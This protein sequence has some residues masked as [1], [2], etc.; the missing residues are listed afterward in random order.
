[1]KT[2]L[3]WTSEKIKSSG[4]RKKLKLIENCRKWFELD[5]VKKWRKHVSECINHVVYYNTV[6]LSIIK[7]SI[8][9]RN[10]NQICLKLIGLLN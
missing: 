2:K 5:F 7:T 9:I 8:K 4:F 6:K 1:M 3:V 10:S